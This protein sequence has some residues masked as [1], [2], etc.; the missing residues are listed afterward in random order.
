MPGLAKSAAE[1]LE[2]RW[3]AE[4][5]DHV[6]ALAWSP[7]GA[8]VA[9]AAVGGPVTIYDGGTG[10]VRRTLAGHGFGTTALSW[11]PSSELLATSGQDGKVKIWS[12]ASGALQHT[13]DGG[14]PWV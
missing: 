10:R 4:I 3:Q 1:P 14:A 5:A 7:D 12:R 2:A 8:T 11:S 6:I 9:A 13:L